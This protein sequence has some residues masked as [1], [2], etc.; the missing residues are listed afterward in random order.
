MQNKKQ[1][2]EKRAGSFGLKLVVLSVLAVTSVYSQ[3]GFNHSA[4]VFIPQFDCKPDTDDLH[5]IAA[6]GSMLLHPDF[7]EVDCLAVAGAYGDQVGNRKTGVAYLYIS[8]PYLFNLA[9]GAKGK[10]WVD[11][12][13]DRDG[14]VVKVA[15]KVEK[16]LLN[17][18]KAWVMEAG[19]S[20]VTKLWVE[21]L[22]ARGVSSD[23]VKSN[24]IVV[25][26]S[27]WNEGSTNPAD[28]AYVQENTLYTAIDDGNAEPR[29]RVDRG[30]DT[31][32]YSKEDIKG[33][34]LNKLSESP[35][36]KVVSMWKNASEVIAAVTTYDNPIITKGGLDFSDVV[37]ARWI[38]GDDVADIDA[39]WAK[40][41]M[42]APADSKGE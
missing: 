13:G 5:S 23:V 19:Q 12:D 38:F 24:V 3:E 42:N 15:D 41:I 22:L 18:G 35:N 9:F 11:A 10:G 37:E 16:V 36:S 34:W 28:L 7:A 33:A 31:P 14:A 8:S 25:Q 1:R 21:M 27:K 32:D 29:T 2:R 20:N 40:Y 6:V 26:H 30:D 17:G 39:F 4:D